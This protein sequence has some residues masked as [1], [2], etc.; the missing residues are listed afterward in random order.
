[1]AELKNEFSWS[2]SR[3]RAFES[4]KRRYYLQHYGFWGGWSPSSPA[5]EI[6]IQKRLNS[7]PQW[8]GLTVHEAAEWVLGQVRRGQ[9]PPKERVVERFLRAAQRRVDESAR[10]LYRQR[11]KKSPGFIDHYYDLDTPEEVW[12]ADL[13]EIGRQIAGLFDNDV[14]LRLTRVPERIVEVEQL[15]QM[16]VGDVPVWV[17]LDVL[18]GDGEGGFVVIDWKTGREHDPETVARQLGVYGAYVLDRYFGQAPDGPGPR[19]VDQI[20][21]MY[22]NLRE[23]SWETRPLVEEQVQATVQTIGDSAAAM[24]EMLTNPAENVARRQDFPMVDQGSAEC[25]RCNYRR[26]CGRESSERP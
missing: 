26:E 19:P 9:F 20:R 23:G 24:R 7:R 8:I 5:R 25:A 12:Q 1:M 22:V 21:A 2:W 3:H 18:V 15:E 10:G 11:P 17:S 14:F 13:D 16:L 4:C 6:Y